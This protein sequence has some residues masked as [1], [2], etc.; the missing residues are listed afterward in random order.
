META[1]P[2]GSF[3]CAQVVLRH[4]I[5]GKAELGVNNDLPKFLKNDAFNLLIE[6]FLLRLSTYYLIPTFLLDLPARSW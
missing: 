3:F 5:D 4:P 2:G 6:I 1:A